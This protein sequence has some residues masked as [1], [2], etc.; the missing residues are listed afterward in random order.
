MP[1]LSSARSRRK[2]GGATAITP[3]GGFAMSFFAV[4]FL[5]DLS[6][7]MP[8]WCASARDRATGNF[9]PRFFFYRSQ[10]HA[11]PSVRQMQAAVF[12]QIDIGR[13]HDLPGM[14]IRIGKISGVSA[15]IGLVRGFE[16]RSALRERE[17]KHGIDLLGRVAVPC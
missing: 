15:V 3:F 16:E 4:S 10:Q 1:R 13:D 7:L 17:G 2:F 12:T 5:A 6:R 8:R 11:L 9:C 14:P